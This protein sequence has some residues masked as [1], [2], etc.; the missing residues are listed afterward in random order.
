MAEV[1]S[2]DSEALWALYPHSQSTI[3]IPATQPRLGAPYTLESQV[4]LDLQIPNLHFFFLTRPFLLSRRTQMC[5]E[6]QATP[7]LR[8]WGQEWILHIAGEPLFLSR[9]GFVVFV[10]LFQVTSLW[11]NRDCKA[12]KFFYYF[13]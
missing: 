6:V 7:G 1:S 11:E 2:A 9:G 12:F 10:L 3:H 13:A 4:H 5:S 8:L